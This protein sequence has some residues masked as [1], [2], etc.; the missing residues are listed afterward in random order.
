MM[1]THQASSLSACQN[2]LTALWRLKS[3][4]LAIRMGRAFD[5]LERL[6]LEQRYSDSQPRGGDGRWINAG[7]RAA[8]GLLRAVP[9]VGAVMAAYDLYEQLS[10]LNSN[11][12]RAVA[13][14]NSRDYR[15][16]EPGSLA[17]T[18][19]GVLTT[20]GNAERLPGAGGC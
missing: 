2:E 13:V 3:D 18:Q 8:R 15:P 1:H 17:L 4:L 14:F 16:S 12:E 9:A 7:G 6:E 11:K 10:Q 19:V 20:G 5:R